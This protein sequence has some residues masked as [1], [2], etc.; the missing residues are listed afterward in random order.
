MSRRPRAELQFGSDSF[1][2]VVANIVGILIILIV[3]AGLRVSRT[4]IVERVALALAQAEALEKLE[5]S[6]PASSLPPIPEAV[7]GTPETS[8]IV[9]LEPADK[10]GEEIAE[11]TPPLPPLV[12]PQEL[13]D[14]AVALESELSA[15]RTEESTNEEKLKLT[16]EQQ[17]ALLEKQRLIQS[18]LAEKSK[19]VSTS[20]K[21]A[22]VAAADL[23]L[24]RQTLARLARQVDEVEGTPAHVEKLEHKITP[25]S[26]VVN[27]KEKHYR[28]EKNRI[29]EVPIEELIES[30]RDQIDRRKD[31]LAKVRQHQGTIGPIKGFTMNYLVKVDTASDL[32]GFRSSQ[33]GYRISLANWEVNPEPD[34]Q[35]ET[36]E[37]ALRK[38]SQFYLSILGTSPDTTL[39]FW[40]YPDSY[41][42]YRRLLKFTHQHGFSVAARPLPKGIPIAGSPNGSKSASQ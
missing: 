2:D 34:L 13:I 1:L 39:T 37:A 25:I 8:Q 18:K 15:L 30:F 27:G 36:A 9:I 10:S 28:L 42:L 6:I 31:W 24:A 14:A 12:V 41:P 33:G 19:E 17:A 26:R 20:Q 4:P 16:S 11:D 22:A 23:D 35:G 32:N 29:A 38:G 3:I 40:V 5:N 7:E 21:K